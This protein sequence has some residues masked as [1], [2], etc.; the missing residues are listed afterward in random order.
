[1]NKSNKIGTD[2]ETSALQQAYN[3][4][5]VTGIDRH[6][7]NRKIINQ[8]QNTND[9]L[10]LLAVAFSFER[11]G[12]SYRKQA[13]S[14]FER[15]LEKPSPIPIIPNTYTS[16]GDPK[17]LF[18]YWEIYS[19]LASLY[20]KEHD[21]DKALKY[22]RLLPKESNY[23]N[24]ADYTRVGDVLL[25]IDI[26]QAVEYYEELK[27]EPVYQ[28]HKRAI[29]IAYSKVLKKQEDT[30]NKQRG[31]TLPQRNIMYC[32]NCGKKQ[33]E[34]AVFC[35]NCGTNVRQFEKT[36]PKCGTKYTS[37]A[38]PNCGYILNGPAQSQQI[39]VQP[40][41][42]PMIPTV[43]QQPIVVCPRCRGTN[44][45]IQAINQVQITDRHHG[46]AWWIFVGWWWVP[47]KWLF[48]T[49][50]ALIV[51]IFKPKKQQVINSVRSVAVC[52]SCGNRWM[53]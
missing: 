46:C 34:T 26:N 11:E 19:T 51:K 22:L 17:P 32:P 53:M 1:M 47:I 23:N 12:V 40:P 13:I 43:H 7:N 5:S 4:T 27:K 39:P 3:N 45:S 25:K 49:L 24:P 37:N 30:L 33:S 52:Q 48:F 21:F 35:E 6:I 16:E 31:N 14:Y 20:E 2:I 18:S 15:F 42:P 41:A 36:C 28:K 8:Y 38:C 50:P 9:P 29:D 10:D 44:V